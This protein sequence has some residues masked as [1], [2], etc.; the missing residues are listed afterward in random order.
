M[1]GDSV[2][3]GTFPTL[4]QANR[5]RHATR[6]AIREKRR[7]IWRAMSWSDFADEADVL[8][9]ALS[10]RGIQ[11]GAYVALISENRPKLFTM[12]AAVHALGA[13]AAP[14]FQDAPVEEM[15][16][17]LQRM[18]PSHVF[19]ENQE[20]IDKV[21]AVLPQCPSI[22]CI[23]YA[24]DRGMSH[25]S[26]P[27][28]VGYDALVAEGAQARKPEAPGPA[29]ADPAFVFLT[30]GTSGPPKAVIHSHAGLIDRAEAAVT[31]MGLDHDDTTLAYLSPGWMAQTLFS[32][33]QPMITG[34]SVSCPES[35]DTLL[36]DLREIAPTVLLSTPRMLETI[37][38]QIDARMQD[39][40]GMNLRMYRRALKDGGGG[41]LLYNFLLYGPLRDAI[42]LSR[43]RAIYSSGDR[44][45]PKL[46]S[47]FDRLGV[48]LRQLYGTTETGFADALERDEPAG[49]GGVGIKLDGVDLKL[50]PAGEVLL[51]SPGFFM[52]YLSDTAH[53]SVDGD[54]WFHTGDFG[55]LTE[56]GVLQITDRV[57]DVGALASGASFAPGAIEARL[58]AH[59]EI[60]E[61]VTFG[62]RREGVVALID[63]EAETVGRWA[64]DREI[65]FTGHAD[66]ASREEVYEMVGELLASVNSELSREESA[67]AS[68][69]RRYLVLPDT[70]SAAQGLLTPTGKARRATIAA[71]YAGLIDALY[72]GQTEVP[73]ELVPGHSDEVHDDVHGG[74]V[75][76]KLRD[77]KT[78]GSLADRRAA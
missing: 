8:A 61:A 64:D 59:P 39:T 72:A 68:Q 49:D 24:E 57:G 73:L 38:G 6:P 17:W 30:S 34:S 3:G 41:G 2:G 45:D 62:H 65:S 12:T 21:L 42:G 13:V 20:Q 1:N 66:L 58:K 40:G 27:Q 69:I 4:L 19:A 23:V 29:P 25:Y 71:H 10:A 26:Q 48:N 75:N 18:Q 47:Y 22:T 76:L 36:G 53:S 55:V 54:G 14:L 9:A 52:G 37:V 5:Q 78:A 7:G 67:A 31:A 50:S 11:Q 16:S 70:I 35:S 46:T 15:S 63:I 56:S 33:I 32:Y 74:A 44:I 77:A 28:L 60:R 43:A 51:R